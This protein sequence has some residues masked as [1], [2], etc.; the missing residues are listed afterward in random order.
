M[1]EKDPAQI[2]RDLAGESLA[3][4]DPTGWFERLYVAAESGDA[5]VPWD[6][7]APSALLAEWAEIHRPH[8]DGR[9]ALVVGC[10]L[11]RDA[12]FLAGY[13]F[14]VTAFDISPTAIRAARERHAG[15]P[16]RYT[17]ADL[18]DLPSHW[19][20]AYDFVLESMTVQ[21]LP[22]SVRPQAAAAVG[23]LVAHG[24]TLLVI[25]AGREPGDPETPGPPWPLTREELDLF[26]VD[27]LTMPFVQGIRDAE[28]IL[29][30][31]AELNR[32]TAEDP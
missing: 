3:A 11:G 4:D 24:G 31:R 12:E 22:R 16:V 28:G 8:G 18:L 23:G 29:R 6:R 7:P 14:D 27:G 19:Q 26:H 2:V 13:G 30:W 25:A 10:G 9:R 20:M 17:T 32:H 1:T 15:S 21:S 5:A